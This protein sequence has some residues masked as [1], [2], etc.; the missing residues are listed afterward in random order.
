MTTTQSVAPTLTVGLQATQ[1]V[2][3]PP[4]RRRRFW[5]VAGLFLFITCLMMLSPF[6]WTAMSV[7][8]PTNVAFSNP[9]VFVYT[10]TLQAFLDLWQTTYFYQYLVNTLIVA[11]ITTILGLLIGLPASYARSRYGGYVSAVLLI[12]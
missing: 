4:S 5:I 9:P 3:R 7:T 12:R 1:Q 10:P 11:V 2:R 6:I 8:K